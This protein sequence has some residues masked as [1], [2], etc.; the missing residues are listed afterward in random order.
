[1]PVGSSYERAARNRA[2]ARPGRRARLKEVLWVFSQVAKPC[3]T[4]S[5]DEIV[6][7]ELQYASALE[8]GDFI[9]RI[10][11]ALLFD[12]LFTAISIAHP[13]QESLAR[14]AKKWPN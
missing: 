9:V 8:V 12:D 11:P 3:S 10:Q 2:A 13:E 7:N 14:R 4:R 6:Q 5:G 1:M